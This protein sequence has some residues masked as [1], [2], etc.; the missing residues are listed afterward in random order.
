MKYKSKI[1]SALEIH[2]FWLL[3][4]AQVLGRTTKRG[5]QG[6]RFSFPVTLAWWVDHPPCTV[7][8]ISTSPHTAFSRGSPASPYIQVSSGPLM[9]LLTLWGDTH[10]GLPIGIVTFTCLLLEHV[11]ELEQTEPGTAEPEFR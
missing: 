4:P 6:R 3:P 8:P 2:H 11:S 5:E 10:P 7:L 1:S 9:S